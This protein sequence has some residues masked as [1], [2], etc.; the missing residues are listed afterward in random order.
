M[1]PVET[2]N[3][4]TV[5]LLK[6]MRPGN[7]SY[8]QNGKPIYTFHSPNTWQYVWEPGDI[9]YIG[10][11]LAVARACGFTP[12]AFYVVNSN[13]EIIGY[14]WGFHSKGIR[15]MITRDKKKTIEEAMLAAVNAGVLEMARRMDSEIAHA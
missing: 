15:M 12:N 13:G 5:R 2:W 14:N 11:L 3:T 1:T 10:F 7:F 8:D 4:E 9:E 6:Q